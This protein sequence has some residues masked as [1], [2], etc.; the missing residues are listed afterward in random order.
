M[1]TV[2]GSA[3][4]IH[5]MQWII[6]RAFPSINAHHLQLVVICGFFSQFNPWT[7][8]EYTQYDF[9]AQDVIMIDA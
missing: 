4:L 6:N 5:A 7:L 3:T 1:N 8:H 9:Q 2:H